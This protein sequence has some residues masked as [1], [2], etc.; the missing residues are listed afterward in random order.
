M[1]KYKIIIPV[2]FVFMFF[3]VLISIFFYKKQEEKKLK[4][5]MLHVDVG[6]YKE[7]YIKDIVNHKDIIENYKINTKKLGKSILE[8]FYKNEKKQ[9]KKGYVEV[10]VLDNTSP[11]VWLTTSYTKVVGSEDDLKDVILC[12][13]NYDKNP[14]CIIKGKYDLSKVGSYPLKYVATDSS[15]N[16]TEI[17]FT[18][19]VVE[20]NKEYV[21]TET[22]F[23]EV[24]KEYKEENNRLGLDISAW[25]KEVNFKKIKEAGVSFVMLRVGYQK[26]IKDIEVLDDYFKKNIESALKEGLDVGVYF[27]SKASTK[28][29]AMNQANFIHKNIKDYKITLPVVFDW[30]IYTSFNKLN[31]SLT[32]LNAIA[33]T[34]MKKI[35][36]Y[37]YTPALYASRNYLEKIWTNEKYDTWLAHYTKKTTYDK[38]YF[39]WQMCMD[40]KID[41]IEGYV[42]IDILYEGEDERRIR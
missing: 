34:F 24:Y 11:L 29:E 41:G 7:V 36:S 39:M 19:N 21:E 22:L 25:Q 37:G 27:Y 30:E 35:E 20:E 23:S 16:K 14:S 8:Y 15:N 12:G 42:D 1:K 32:D 18:L 33:D 31:I 10:N 38:D 28:E 2:I 26:D 6:V 40:G 9:K 3:L 5:N 13:D 17:D 4:E